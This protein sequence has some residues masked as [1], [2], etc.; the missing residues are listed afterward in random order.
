MPV[1]VARWESNKILPSEHNKP[2][3][4]YPA[5]T[6]AVVAAGSKPKG[7]QMQPTPAVAGPGVAAAT[8]LLK[9]MKVTGHWVWTS[10]H[11]C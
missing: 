2:N 6:K 1:E 7:K 8:A 3:I 11:S 10:G 5:G 4:L 9:G